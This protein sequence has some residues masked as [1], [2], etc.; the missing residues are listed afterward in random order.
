MTALTQLPVNLYQR[1]KSLTN[2]LYV[3]KEPFNLPHSL[4]LFFRYTPKPQAQIVLWVGNKGLWIK[5]PF[6]QLHEIQKMFDCYLSQ[7][8][9]L[10]LL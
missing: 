6:V 10:Y 5:P 8:N 3:F 2:T 4:L 9:M 1:C 7:K